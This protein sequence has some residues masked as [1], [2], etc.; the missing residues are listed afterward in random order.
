MD[1]VIPETPAP[2][3]AAATTGQAVAAAAAMLTHLGR[4]PTEPPPPPTAAAAAAAAQPAADLAQVWQQLSILPTLNHLV[5]ICCPETAFLPLAAAS[6]MTSLTKL[7]L[8]SLVSTP[9]ISPAAAVLPNLQTLPHFLR[10]RRPCISRTEK[11]PLSV[12]KA[13]GDSLQDLVIED[14]QL[15]RLPEWFG[16]TLTGLTSLVLRGNELSGG[17]LRYVPDQQLPGSFSMLQQL[18]VRRRGNIGSLC[19]GVR[20]YILIDMAG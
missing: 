13:L 19:L 11:E 20:G 12:L 17:E 1:G 9:T 8:K 14:C 7:Q 2:A 3:V 6:C 4:G 10:R 16:Q 15:K 18:Q 5:L